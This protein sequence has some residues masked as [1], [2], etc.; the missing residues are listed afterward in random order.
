MIG[1]PRSSFGRPNDGGAPPSR[2]ARAGSAGRRPGAP[3]RPDTQ[4]RS[5]LQAWLRAV[6][7]AGVGKGQ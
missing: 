4:C 6:W 3:R 1:R 2:R 5:F 7:G